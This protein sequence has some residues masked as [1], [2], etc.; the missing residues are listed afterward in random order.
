MAN[1]DQICDYMADFVTDEQAKFLLVQSNTPS[2]TTAGRIIT[3]SQYAG[4][5]MVV[6][7]SIS[8]SGNW[9]QNISVVNYIS[10]QS[11]GIWMQLSTAA[12]GGLPCKILLYK[13]A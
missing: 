12:W 9:Y 2:G 6:G 1:L 8:T 3:D 13:Y 4:K 11:D 10:V 5:Y 7:Y